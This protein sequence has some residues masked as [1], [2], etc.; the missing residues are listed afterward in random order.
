MRRVYDPVFGFPGIVR[1]GWETTRRVVARHPFDFPF[2][3]EPLG[4]PPRGRS[5][6]LARQGIVPLAEW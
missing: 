2:P 1:F 4:E 3:Y 6:Y 5:A